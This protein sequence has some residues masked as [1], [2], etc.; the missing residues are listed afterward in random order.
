MILGG[1]G[2]GAIEPEAE[3]LTLE[4]ARDSLEVP[5]SRVDTTIHS[6]FSLSYSCK[7]GNNTY[8]SF[9]SA[10]VSVSNFEPSRL[11]SR[12]LGPS[13]EAMV[14]GSWGRCLSNELYRASSFR[15]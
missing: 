7:D 12:V 11:C 4:I 6:A 14:F 5:D 1:G 15:Q 13:S 9:S 3:D 2:D 8:P 10:S